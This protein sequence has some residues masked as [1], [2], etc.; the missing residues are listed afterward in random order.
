MLLEGKSD[1]F[2]GQTTLRDVIEIKAGRQLQDRHA[3]W[4]QPCLGFVYPMVAS[5]NSPLTGLL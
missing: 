1:A 4:V 3:P 5:F 2:L